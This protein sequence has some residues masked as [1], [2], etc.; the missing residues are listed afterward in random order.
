MMAKGIIVLD[1]IPECCVTPDGRVKCP[2][3]WNTQFCSRFS[4]KGL[5][6]TNGEWEEIHMLGI[7]PEWC[8]IR[9]LPDKLE[10]DNRNAHE[11]F[12]YVCGWNDCLSEIEGKM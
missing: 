1:S 2:F 8:P 10:S 11:D 12:D 9:T 7:K 5:D 3:A 4:P 6:M